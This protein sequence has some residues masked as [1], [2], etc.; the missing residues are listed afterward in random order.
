MDNYRY[1]ALERSILT[2][3][4]E[5]LPVREERLF[6]SF[7]RL[8]GHTTHQQWQHHDA[9]T[10]ARIDLLVVAEGT[11]PTYSQRPGQMPQSVLRLGTN[12]ATSTDGLGFLSWPVDPA[13]LGKELNRHGGLIVSKSNVPPSPAMFAVDGTATPMTPIEPASKAK[14][15]HL[16]QWPP[17][18]L[19]TGT[20]HMRLATLLT[21]KAMSLAE[22]AHRSAL[23]LPVCEAFVD[24]LLRANLIFEQCVAAKAEPSRNAPVQKTVPRSLLD[25]IR[26]RLGISA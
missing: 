1:T 21:S 19:L 8:L 23:P 15:M 20:G 9:A 10:D 14:L 16:R 25:S 2:F 3:C 13:A 5:G 6:K 4:V 26:I 7:V 24:A 18:H 12:R 11:Q 22:L 17:T